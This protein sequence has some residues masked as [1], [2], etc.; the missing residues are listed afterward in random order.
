MGLRFLLAELELSGDDPPGLALPAE[1]ALQLVGGVDEVGDRDGAHRSFPQRTA[2]PGVQ[3]VRCATNCRENSIQRDLDVAHVHVPEHEQEFVPSDSPHEVVA[4]HRFGECYG[5]VLQRAVAG[6]V[7]N[8]VVDGAEALQVQGAEEEVFHSHPRLALLAAGSD[9]HLAFE[10]VLDRLGGHQAGQAV[11]EGAE[12]RGLL[13]FSQRGDGLLVAALS[14]LR[15]GEL[16][17]EIDNF[18]GG[19]FTFHGAPGCGEME[20]TEIIE[21]KSIAKLRAF[22][23][24][25]WRIFAKI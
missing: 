16:V 3:A 11:R 21:Q 19:E 20:E 1:L 2:E 23:N 7:A 18:S 9:R 10:T 8:P 15:K 6:L 13:G 24:K 12:V 5:D 17:L 4:S 25:T 22:V 14:A